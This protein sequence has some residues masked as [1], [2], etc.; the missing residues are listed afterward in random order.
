MLLLF[1]VFTHCWFHFKAS[2]FP[3]IMASIFRH[4]CPR[5]NNFYRKRAF[6]P[7]ITPIH[8]PWLT[9]CIDWGSKIF[10]ELIMVASG[11]FLCSGHK[12]PW[13][14]GV[15]E[16]GSTWENYMVSVWGSSST[17]ENQMDPGLENTIVICCH[18]FTFYFLNFELGMNGATGNFLFYQN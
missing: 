13:L 4:I 12:V 1:P 17:N 14:H 7:T 3:S 5:L 18:H 11:W 15:P 2:S 10:P 9:V 6:F 8:F 16:V